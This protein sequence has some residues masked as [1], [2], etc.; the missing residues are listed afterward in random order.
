MVTT[1]ITSGIH[2]L[3][4][5][6]KLIISKY[7]LPMIYYSIQDVVIAYEAVRLVIEKWK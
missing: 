7:I 2:G 5:V 4:E 1:C 6:Y 3:Y